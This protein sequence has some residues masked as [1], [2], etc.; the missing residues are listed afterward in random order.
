MRDTEVERALEGIYASSEDDSDNEGCTTVQED[1]SEPDINT[2]LDNL[3][4]LSDNDLLEILE[5]TRPCSPPVLIQ[6][7]PS[8]SPLQ[9]T[10]C[11]AMETNTM[12]SH[13]V[14]EVIYF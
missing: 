2:V 11:S 4:G 3:Q 14:V 7:E 10:S 13:S 5:G 12:P 6:H 1:Y 9:P 8:T